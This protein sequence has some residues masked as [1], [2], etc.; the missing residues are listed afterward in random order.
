[1]DNGLWFKQS[2]LLGM[3]GEET[4][5]CNG[6]GCNHNSLQFLVVLG[7]AVSKPSCHA[8]GY[9]AFY[10]LV[11]V[12]CI[13]LHAW[14]SYYSQPKALVRYQNVVHWQDKQTQHL[15]LAPGKLLSTKPPNTFTSLEQGSKPLS[16]S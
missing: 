8:L 9:N 13:L 7:V 4:A 3:V 11:W 2:Q 10:S 6:L 15:F 5:L 16:A 14:T 12:N 1:M